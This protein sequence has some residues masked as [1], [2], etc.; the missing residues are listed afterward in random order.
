M[1]KRDN[2]CSIP[3]K[4]NY[5]S[6]QR[7][8]LESELMVLLQLQVKGSESN[9]NDISTIQKAYFLRFSK[10]VMNNIAW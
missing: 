5:I 2:D 1:G 9:V 6:L 4:G 10:H 8:D 3:Q 7:K